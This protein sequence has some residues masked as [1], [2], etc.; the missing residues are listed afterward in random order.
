MDEYDKYGLSQRQLF[1]GG[2]AQT[3][4]SLSRQPGMESFAGLDP[5]GASMALYNNPAACC[6]CIPAG[7]RFLF[8]MLFQTCIDKTTL[9]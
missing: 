8:F 9:V 7:G 5:T 6:K 3:G 4:Q 1:N 2:L